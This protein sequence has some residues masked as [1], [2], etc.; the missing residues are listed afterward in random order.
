MKNINKTAFIVS[1]LV[2]IAAFSVL[3]MTSMPE[4]FRYTWVGLN[5]WNGVEGLAFTVRYFLHTSVTVT[6]YYYGSFAI[7]DLVAALCYFSPDLALRICLEFSVSDNRY[8]I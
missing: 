4:E 6:Y 3:S 8:F 2:L 1:L 5:P 7:S